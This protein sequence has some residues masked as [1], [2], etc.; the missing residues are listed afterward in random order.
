MGER[1]SCLY[2]TLKV[3]C[4]RK[5]AWLFIKFPFFSENTLCLGLNIN[6][7]VVYLKVVTKAKRTKASA[8]RS[9]IKGGVFDLY[10]VSGR[11]AK[12]P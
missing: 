9:E 8:I 11:A 5:R 10:S 12:T 3:F 4:K 7:S 1:R 2:Q 6:Y